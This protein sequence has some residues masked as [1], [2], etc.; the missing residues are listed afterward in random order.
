MKS[1]SDRF[2]EHLPDVLNEFLYPL[3]E[4]KEGFLYDKVYLKNNF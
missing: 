3:P 1:M 2:I 4:G